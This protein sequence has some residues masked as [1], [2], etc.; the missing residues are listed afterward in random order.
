MLRKAESPSKPGELGSRFALAIQVGVLEV[1][2]RR[3]KSMPGKP[4]YQSK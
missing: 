3:Q 2:A 4:Q 1:F